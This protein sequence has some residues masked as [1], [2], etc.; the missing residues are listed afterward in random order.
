MH[1][2]EKLKKPIFILAPM[3]G[4]TD[5]VFRQ[6]LV[7]VACPQRQQAGLRGGR[8]KPDVF[9]TEFI[10]VDGLFSKGYEKVLET[11]KFTKKEQP[12]VA[13]IWGS[14]PENFYKAAGLIK[15][16]GFDGIDIN[17]GCP[18]K[19]VIKKGAG[20]A[21]IKNPKLAKE[22]IEA[23]ISGA[24]GLPVS[25]KTR[26]GFDRIDI[27]NWVTHLL[28]TQ[29]SALTL[30]LRIVPEMSKVPAHWEEVSKA[31]KIKNKFKSKALVI[32]NGDVKSLKEAR[33]KCERYGIDGVMIGQGIF[34]N[35]WLFNEDI[36]VQNR[37]SG[38]RIRLLVKHLE[39]FKKTY[40]GRKHFELMKK[41]VKCY[42]NN[43]ERSSDSRVKLMKTKTLDELIQA[44]KQLQTI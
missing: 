35:V 31:V 5:T 40:E 36:D 20:S 8:G 13:Q 38:Q 22:I 7:S 4:V 23:T 43:F 3:D 29:I 27:E 32:G 1:F 6:I 24:E 28:Q 10:P 30:H 34:E 26:I 9:F 39:L 17:M 14:N 37:A 33:E 16:L 15:K 25:V 19:N 42:V 12:I 18:D 21:L 44:S 2:W 11:L 41:F